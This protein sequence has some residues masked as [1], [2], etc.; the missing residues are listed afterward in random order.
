MKDVTNIVIS[1]LFIH[2]TSLIIVFM[3][4]AS[5]EKMLLFKN[6]KQKVDIILDQYWLSVHI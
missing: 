6:Q 3:I 2:V 1:V 4:L 5:I